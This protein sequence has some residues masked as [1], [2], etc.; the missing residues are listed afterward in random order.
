MLLSKVV[1]LIAANYFISFWEAPW[2]FYSIFWAICVP[3]SLNAYIIFH[4]I[5]RQEAY[6]KTLTQTICFFNNLDYIQKDLQGIV[7][8]LPF[9]WNSMWNYERQYLINCQQETNKATVPKNVKKSFFLFRDCVWCERK[10]SLPVASAIYRS[11][12]SSPA[13]SS[14]VNWMRLQQ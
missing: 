7:K 11:F 1:R 9:L 3:C 10:M 8:L 6:W 13:F 2:D 14:R 5:L 4:L 12:K